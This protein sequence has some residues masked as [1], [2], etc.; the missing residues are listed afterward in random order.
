MVSAL[1]ETFR[2]LKS[3]TLSHIV[4]IKDIEQSSRMFDI[5]T[6]DSHHFS[7]LVHLRGFYFFKEHISKLTEIENVG[8]LL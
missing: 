4:E 1:M 8:S 3:L 2:L 7:H 5:A 6:T